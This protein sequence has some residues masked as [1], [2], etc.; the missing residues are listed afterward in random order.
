MRPKRKVR[1]HQ[2]AG[3]RPPSRKVVEIQWELNEALFASLFTQ[4]PDEVIRSEI[5][6]LRFQIAKLITLMEFLVNFSCLKPNSYRALA[7]LYLLLERHREE[8]FELQG[9]EGERRGYQAELHLEDLAASLDE[10]SLPPE[11]RPGGRA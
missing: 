7:E 5:S 2:S 11:V 1:G 9:Q 6:G 10:A 8:H 4:T 3:R